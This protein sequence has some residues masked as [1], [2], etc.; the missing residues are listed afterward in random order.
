[1]LRLPELQERFVAALLGGSSD[2]LA[3]WILDDG[4]EARPRHGCADNISVERG[5]RLRW[6]DRDALHPDGIDPHR[7]A[8]IDGATAAITCTQPPSITRS[9]RSQQASS[10]SSSSR[11]SSNPAQHTA[12]SIGP[13]SRSTRPTIEA[14]A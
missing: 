3:P 7:R 1:M 5:D 14:T 12:T 13:S 10:V 11:S 4:I 2:S 6:I 9:D 8:F